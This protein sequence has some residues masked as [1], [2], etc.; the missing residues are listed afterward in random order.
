MLE[1]VLCRKPQLLMLVSALV[2]G[3]GLL[4][5]P[6]VSQADEPDLLP[7]LAEMIDRVI[8]PAYDQF[9][10]VAADEVTVVEALCK[11]PDAGRLEA[12]RVGF[13]ALVDG[14]SRVEAMRFGPARDENRFEKL[15]FWPDRRSRGLRQVQ[16]IVR[17]EDPSGLDPESLA[18]KSV[19]VQGI[20]AL[21]YT[22][23]GD[24]A[25][26][27]L[28]KPN[29]FRCGYALATSRRVATTARELHAAWNGPSGYGA[30]MKSAGPEKQT[31]R[32]GGEAMQEILRSAAEM[33]TIDRDFKI[34]RVIGED[35]KETRVKRAPLW[36]SG[37]WLRS[38]DGNIAF[39]ED[40]FAGDTLAG[41]LDEENASIPQEVR[42]E[43]EQARRAVADAAV[44]VDETQGDVDIGS[45]AFE[46]LSYATLPLHGA[47]EILEG[48]LPE[49]LG[50]I[51]G[52]N[53]LDGD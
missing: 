43:L 36:R 32:S 52:F 23:S 7:V 18:E 39:V 34:A 29:S 19:A 3:V 25:D 47:A 22:L 35:L 1:T 42:F 24:D 2:F 37:L 48:R 31:Y 33:L 53:S 17:T 26:S 49:A 5:A 28:L 9:A 46:A 16:E 15:F 30:L 12:A 51:I 38:I 4:T 44:L 41:L 27:D 40:L 11:N 45:E 13:A 6:S 50:L 21:D 14:F 20:L 10:S 8:I